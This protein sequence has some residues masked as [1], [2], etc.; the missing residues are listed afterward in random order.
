MS[1]EL[2]MDRGEDN[3]AQN[4]VQEANQSR[5]RVRF[6]RSAALSNRIIIS[7]P[8]GQFIPGLQN[9]SPN[10]SS[11]NPTNA[12]GGLFIFDLHQSRV[13]PS[14]CFLSL[15]A[16]LAARG[17]RAEI[18]NTKEMRLVAFP[19][20]L[21]MNNPPTALVGFPGLFT[22]SLTRCVSAKI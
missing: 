4:T 12:V 15:R 7:S 3:T 6:P 10:Y 2:P 19:C 16:A 18:G 8:C 20:R 1:L 17:P 13:E 9:A 21:R 14:R 5:V 11:S 22:R